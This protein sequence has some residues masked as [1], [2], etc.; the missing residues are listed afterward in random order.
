MKIPRVP[1]WQ[2][3]AIPPLVFGIGFALNALVMA[4]N[5]N[6][7]PVLIPGGC[8]PG[9]FDGD[10]LHTCMT[11]LTKLRVLGDWI[12]IRSIGVA[13]I[14]DFL[15]WFYAVTGVPGVIAWLTLNLVEAQKVKSTSNGS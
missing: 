3:I 6:Q 7:M 1:Y 13:S 11:H 14:G 9:D 8:R 10:T 5:G 4:F 2:L 15:E 12:V